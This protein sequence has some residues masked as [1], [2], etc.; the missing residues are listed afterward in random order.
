MLQEL[1]NACLRRNY[2]ERPNFSRVLDMLSSML[3]SSG[4]NT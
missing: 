4:L 2:K 1:V 3:S